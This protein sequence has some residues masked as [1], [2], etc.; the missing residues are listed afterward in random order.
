MLD[1]KLP[2]VDGLEVLQQIRADP[3]TRLVPV[4]ILTSSSEERD[5]INGYDLGAN[6]FVGKPI[7]FN[8]FAHAVAQLG[9]YWLM[10]NQ[11]APRNTQITPRKQ[12]A[13]P[14]ARQRA[15]KHSDAAP[16]RPSI[17][18]VTR[19]QRECRYCSS[20]KP[21]DPQRRDACIARVSSSLGPDGDSA[22]SV[23]DA[24]PT[25]KWRDRLWQNSWLTSSRALLVRRSRSTRAD[26][27]ADSCIH[28]GPSIFARHRRLLRTARNSCTS[29][30][31]CWSC[32]P[33]GHALRAA[34]C[35]VH[36]DGN[37]ARAPAK[38]SALMSS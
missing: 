18:P 25:S 16:R 22:C 3:R 28:R 6:S 23:C 20:E 11:P 15:G 34:R 33:R 32:R 30:P 17:A 2:R 35:R 7:D 12:L 26:A 24:P 38:R 10:I 37:E 27:H 19:P 4:V 36:A 5:V 9:I 21:V 29:E 14:Q 31:W 13:N 8:E 1:L